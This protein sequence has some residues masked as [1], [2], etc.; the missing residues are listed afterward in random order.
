MKRLILFSLLFIFVFAPEAEAY[1]SNGNG[2]DWESVPRIIYGPG[3]EAVIRER[4]SREPYKT[5]Y[6]R[7]QSEAG[8]AYD[9]ENH[10]VG[11]EQQKANISCSAAF[12]YAIDRQ[13]SGGSVVPFDSED[14]R[15]AYG[16]LSETLLANMYTL[17]RMQGFDNAGLDILTSQ[18]LV[19]YST[20]YD[21]L[22]GAG[23]PF[24]DEALVR[25]NIVALASDFYKDWTY[26]LKG[27][28]N[29]YN[30]NHMSK[31]GSAMG[32]AAIVMNGYEP[33]P[34]DDLEGYKKPEEWIKFA[35][36]RTEFIVLDALIS[37]QGSYAEGPYYYSYTAI[38]HEPFMRALNRYT[39][40]SGIDV[41]GVHYD[42]LYTDPRNALVHD[43]LL[44]VRMP[45][46]TAPAFDDGSPGGHYAWGV[47]GDL[48]NSGLYNWAWQ[49]LPQSWYSG[50]SINQTAFTIAAYDDAVLPVSPDE[51]G[52]SPTQILFDGGQAVFRQ[53][54]EADSMYLLV[55]AEHGK[56]AGWSQK[57]DYDIIEGTGG[58]DHNDPGHISLH[59]YGRPLL[60]DGG[61]L[62]WPNHDKV[63]KA[64]N[65]NILLVDDKGPELPYL[66]PPT[67]DFD[68]NGE[69][70]IVEGSEGGWVP[71]DDGEA[72][73]ID[74][75]DGNDFEMARI[76]TRYF[77]KVPDTEWTRTVIFARQRY[78]VVYDEIEVLD[79]G[80]H[81]LTMQWHGNGGGTSGGTFDIST[82]NPVRWT[83]VDAGVDVF[84]YAT[85]GFPA[86]AT[87]EKIHDAGGW[88]EK[89]HN[90]WLISID[91]P[92]TTFA[93]VLFPFQIAEADLHTLSHACEA[94]HLACA[95]IIPNNSGDGP[96]D[97]VY[98][99]PRSDEASDMPGCDALSSNGEQFASFCDPE[100]RDDNPWSAVSAIYIGHSTSL[101]RLEVDM[102]ESDRPITALIERDR[103][104]DGSLSGHYSVDGGDTAQLAISGLSAFTEISGLCCTES[105]FRMV[106]SGDFEIA[107]SEMNI[108]HLTLKAQITP[109]VEALNVWNPVPHVMEKQP[110]TID[111]AS[112]CNISGELD[113]SL[114]IVEQPWYSSATPNGMSITPDYP[115]DYI[116]K[117]IAQDDAETAEL[118]LRFHALPAEEGEQEAETEM[119]SESDG[120]Q[121]LDI[122]SEEAAEEEFEDESEDVIDGD[123]E[124]DT[125]P[126]AEAVSEEDSKQDQDGNAIDE[127]D[128]DSG[129][130]CH[131]SA[132]NPA[133]LLLLLPLALLLIVRRRLI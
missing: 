68:E 16:R 12:I 38:N 95:D 71:G 5:L 110:V 83:Y 36:K 70:V 54:W 108:C 11:P 37:R 130:N 53:S 127:S 28:M 125:E 6:T 99:R 49:H 62:G 7:L 19:T 94:A 43:W 9:L 77:E 23:Y 91:A 60:I 107:P 118:L 21:T 63:C 76:R 26:D 10:D 103:W 97:R 133:G 85:G 3:D 48:P 24:Q 51:T 8:Q 30:E 29:A 114:E 93:S 119:E 1:W 109:Q 90:R 2:M 4:L 111:L 33:D 47:M 86:Y 113:S 34:T 102:L 96:H 32:V 72:Y 56:A 88:A 124:L 25:E 50:G 132:D 14:E 58:H 66:I 78:F 40:G 18:E 15:L 82:Y 31:S 42:D 46:G 131:Q 20:A 120:D 55:A 81:T 61:Y 115:G 27:A 123:E 75:F 41:D 17:S 104:G 84:S 52:W 79:G 116:V 64:D 22:R 35:V 122:I 100:A 39:G 92:Q 44:R 74:S 126:E 101:K 69:L 87:D 121:E 67:F 106:D 129:C 117:V 65:H 89:T 59:A 73:I 112:S 57:K 98:A 80:S 45:D 105:G 128:A 13:V